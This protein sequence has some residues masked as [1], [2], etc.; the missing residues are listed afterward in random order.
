[1]QA[2][3]DSRC[4]LAAALDFKVQAGNGLKLG[5]KAGESATPLTGGGSRHGRCG[6]GSWRFGQ[7]SRGL[8]GQCRRSRNFGWHRQIQRAFLTAAGQ[9]DGTD[10]NRGKAM[11][12]GGIAAAT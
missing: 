2:M 5:Q 1:L 11:P 3:A 7:A 10:H 9:Q 12:K 8:R 4:H 6:R